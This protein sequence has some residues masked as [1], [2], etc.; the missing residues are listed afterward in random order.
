MPVFGDKYIG[1]IDVTF[2]QTIVNEWADNK[3]KIFKKIKNY[4]SNVFD[5]AMSIEIVNK[6]PM[7]IITIPRGESIIKDEKIIDFYDKEELLSF[8]KAIEHDNSERFTFFSLLAFTGLRKGEAFALTW[9]DVDFK[10]KMLNI[11]KTITRGLNGRLITNT[12]K[13]KSGKRKILLDDNTVSVLKKYYTEST[14]VLSINRDGLIFN[15]EGTPYN[16]TVSRSWLNIIYK[17][18]P[19]L[20]KQITTHGFRHT[21][22]SL[23]FES[24]AQAKDVQER[25]GHSDIQ[26]TMNIYTHVTESQN[27]KVISNFAAFMHNSM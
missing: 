24:G 2:C 1:K 11:D 20:T 19:E 21:H 6:N 23:L 22:A 16:P 10:N 7:R 9:S 27:K 17:R 26:T 12:P 14:K 3:P 13:T 15:H 25:L 4:T 5:Y 8:L 18:H